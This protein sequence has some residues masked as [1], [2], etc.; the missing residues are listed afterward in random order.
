MA[1]FE[2]PS[3]HNGAAPPPLV[4]AAALGAVQQLWLTA[5]TSQA[6]FATYARNK[7]P[8][9]LAQIALTVTSPSAPLPIAR[10]ASTLYGP[11]AKCSS[12]PEFCL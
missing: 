5:C 12:A 6:H 3:L 8:Y 9:A 10:D 7:R 11:R 2:A 1:A 4:T